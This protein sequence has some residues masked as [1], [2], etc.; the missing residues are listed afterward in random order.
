[1]DSLKVAQKGETWEQTMKVKLAQHKTNMSTKRYRVLLS[2]L[3]DR[4]FDNG[5]RMSELGSLATSVP[6]RSGNDTDVLYGYGNLVKKIADTDG[7]TEKVRY[8]QVV[9]A[10]TRRA[11]YV[12]V[13][14]K[15][16]AL[17]RAKTVVSCLPLGV[18]KS[19]KY[20]IKWTPALKSEVTDRFK[21]L[22]RTGIEKM[23]IKFENDFGEPKTEL[24]AFDAEPTWAFFWKIRDGIWH[25]FSTP[26]YA[27]KMIKMTN[28]EVQADAV[29]I[30]KKAYPTDD[31]TV[32]RVKITRWLTDPFSLGSYSFRGPNVD[33]SVESGENDPLH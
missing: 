3:V 10:V 29:K 11:E 26:K 28:A 13:E 31:M 17:Y 14:V 18:L 6:A 25:G 2:L 5:G 19:K 12:L 32:D 21:Q 8:K 27:H 24:L 15:G 1:M 23:V 33:I 16:G 22:G 7:V 20:G 30:F 4:A 9:K